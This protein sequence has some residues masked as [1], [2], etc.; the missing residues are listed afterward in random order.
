MAL[1]RV[2]VA[3]S[4]GVDSSLAAALLKKKGYDV[5]GVHMRLWDDPNQPRIRA[6]LERTCQILGIPLF[7][8]DFE[9]EFH[10]HVISCFNHDYSSGLTPNPCISC[11]E[12]IKFGYLFDKVVSMGAGYLA[13]GHY[14]RIDQTPD[15]YRL[16]KAAD[17]MKD[18]S[19]F[20]YTLGQKQLWHLLFPLSELYKE[21]VRKLAAEM[22]LL[23]NDRPESQDLCFIPGNDYRSFVTQHVPPKPGNI[24]DISSN[25]LGKHNGLAGYTIGQRQGLGI[26]SDK[27]LHVISLD[28][29]TNQ[30]MVGDK[31][32]LLHNGLAARQLNWISGK[33]PR[34]FS[35]NNTAKIRSKA[36]E[37]PVKIKLNGDI[38]NVEFFEPQSAIAPGQSIVFYQG[39]TVLGGGVIDAILS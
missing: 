27:P 1:K 16:L 21:N 14:A 12:K 32:Q 36:P 5:T 39:E 4:G 26:S 6:D 22:N 3:M 10:D 23:S 31:E 11:N 35:R 19:Y 28:A 18:Q 33:A 20:L 2:A 7:Y 9:K 37:V 17:K 15:G 34:D 25:I 30:V 38:A 24:V 13:T 29:A 8:F